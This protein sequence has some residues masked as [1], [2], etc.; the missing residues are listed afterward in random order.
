MSVAGSAG[1]G[2][3]AGLTSTGGL[4]AWAQPTSTTSAQALKRGKAR[5]MV[6][7]VA[8]APR[9][10]GQTAERMAYLQLL[11]HAHA[12]VE[13]HRFLAHMARGVGDPDLCRRNRAR[14]VARIF[15]LVDFRARKARH[16]L[17]LLVRDEHV[18]HAVLQRLERADGNAEL[19][20]RFEILERDR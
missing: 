11:G 18:D 9:E 10:R 12:A 6:I 8:E 13:L 7:D 16:R 14:A 4:G 20:A 3:G 1:S 19:L 5:E 2:R 17:R 15:G